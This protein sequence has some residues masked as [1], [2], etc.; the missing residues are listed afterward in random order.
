[1]DSFVRYFTEDLQDY[2]TA[3]GIFIVPYL[4]FISLLG[5]VVQRVKDKKENNY[6]NN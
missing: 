5:Y 3:Y 4:L 2:V 6:M 1:M